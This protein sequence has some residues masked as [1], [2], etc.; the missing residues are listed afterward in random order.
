MLFYPAK[1]PTRYIVTD[2]V[3]TCLKSI[4]VDLPRWALRT[5]THRY[6]CRAVKDEAGVG[7]SP[8]QA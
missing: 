1:Q 6:R 5:V 2:R 4:H 3:P 8:V 7:W